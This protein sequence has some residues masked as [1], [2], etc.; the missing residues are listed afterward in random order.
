[1]ERNVRRIVFILS[2]F[3]ALPLYQ[4]DVFGQ[5]A[6]PRI[7]VSGD[8][9]LA[10]DSGRTFTPWGF[11]YDRDS[12]YRLIEDYSKYLNY[13]VYAALAATIAWLS[14]RAYRRQRERVD[15]NES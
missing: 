6:V 15:Q 13:A 7:K 1:M 14:V 3:I 10:S 8:R 12:K 4:A 9:F 11:N 5:S 2:T